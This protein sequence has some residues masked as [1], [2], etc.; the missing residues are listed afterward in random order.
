MFK[1]RRT[2]RIASSFLLFILGLIYG[3]F[4]ENGDY[5]VGDAPPFELVWDPSSPMRG[6][7]R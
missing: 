3:P 2:E 6:E 4:V 7:P 5:G 1:V